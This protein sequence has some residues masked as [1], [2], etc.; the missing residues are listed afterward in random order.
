[1][2][3]VDATQKTFEWIFLFLSWPASQEYVIADWHSRNPIHYLW[4]LRVLPSM[5]AWVLRP[6]LKSIRPIS[7]FG[8]SNVLPSFSAYASVFSIV[9][10]VGTPYT[11]ERCSDT[12]LLI[13][14]G[15]YAL[16]TQL[17]CTK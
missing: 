13:V 1:M 2:R 8:R 12:M 14:Q 15:R 11:R 7:S 3:R 17:H 4:Q 9:W 10:S 5:G 6:F 16:T